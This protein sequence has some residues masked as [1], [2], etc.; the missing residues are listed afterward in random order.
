MNTICNITVYCYTIKNCLPCVI[1]AARYGEV[2]WL[3]KGFILWLL[4]VSTAANIHVAAGTN[5]K[6]GGRTILGF[7]K[8]GGAI[9]YGCGEQTA[10]TEERS[11]RT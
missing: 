7:H 2:L 6:S 9:N 8:S 1:R 4:F 5:V 10:V 11:K 3:F